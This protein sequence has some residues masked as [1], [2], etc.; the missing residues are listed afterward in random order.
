[1]RVT[2][3]GRPLSIVLLNSWGKAS[4]YSDAQHIRDWLINTERRIPTAMDGG[5]AGNAGA[6][7]RPAPAPAPGAP[8]EVLFYGSFI[9][10]QGAE[11]IIDAA[12][13]YQGP[14][15]RW[16]LLGNGPL[17]ETCK[18]NAQGLTNV[19][20]EPWLPYA[21]LPARIRRADILL[22][23]FGTTPKA[24]RVIPNKV[25]QALACGKPLVTCRA[26]AYPAG[27]M[28]SGNHGITWVPAGDSAALAASVA[29][30]ARQPER[31]AALGRGARTG[32]EKFFSATAIRRQ[33]QAALAAL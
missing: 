19:V 15:V 4:K 24:Q 12:R 11:V 5:S 26:P 22:G 18:Q 13:A 28:E 31:L 21:Q 6:V 27:L 9:A 30:L 29:G 14:A 33:L 8:I 7:F 32:Y 25:F 3:A 16:V 1:M 17:L 2:L 20:F 10:L 23:V